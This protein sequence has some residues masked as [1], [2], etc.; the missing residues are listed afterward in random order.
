MGERGTTSSGQSAVAPPVVADVRL[1][2]TS[3]PDYGI[4][5]SACISVPDPWEKRHLPPLVEMIQ[6]S[7]IH[8]SYSIIPSPMLRSLKDFVGLGG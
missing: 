6:H 5:Q 2:V 8:P 1:Q 4:P 7:P 3:R